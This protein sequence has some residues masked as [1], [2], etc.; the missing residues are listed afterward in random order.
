[1]QVPAAPADA[2]LKAVIDKLASFVAKN[3]EGFEAL[4]RTK[5]ADNPKFNFLNGGES[6]DYYR[7][8]VWEA[9]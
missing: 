4:T 2:E 5:Q 9:M 7:Y 1:M 6:Y 8:K 3:G